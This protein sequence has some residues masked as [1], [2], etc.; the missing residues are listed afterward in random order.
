[1]SRI[2]F[3]SADA[4][5]SPTSIGFGSRSTDAWLWGVVVVALVL[6]VVLT[7]YG[8]GLGLQEGNPIARSFFSMLGVIEAMLLLKGSVMAMALVAW[9]AL[10]RQ[11]RAVVPIGVA[12][13]WLV[14]SAINATLILQV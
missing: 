10:P 1:M 6:D 3:S 7:Y 4:T 11:Y 2:Q 9:I 12:L 5:D 8:L 13:P 14:A